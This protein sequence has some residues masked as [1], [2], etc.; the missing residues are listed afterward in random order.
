VADRRD[1]LV[2]GVGYLGF[3][4]FEQQGAVLLF[5]DVGDMLVKA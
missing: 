4:D 3:E 1:T 2:L 5:D